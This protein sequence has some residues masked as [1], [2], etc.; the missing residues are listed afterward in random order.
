MLR[1]F[2]GNPSTHTINELT[3]GDEEA[4]S[5]A[6]GGGVEVKDVQGAEAGFGFVL[7]DDRSMP[8]RRVGYAS[9]PEAG[10]GREKLLEALKGVA[11]VK[12]QR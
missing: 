2:C 10:G 12:G 9:Y 7:Y 8:L 1:K 3:I 11:T 4:R 5:C 6:D